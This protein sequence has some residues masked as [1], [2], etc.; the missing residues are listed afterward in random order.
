MPS[1]FLK[2]YFF[3]PIFFC[4][5]DYE[6]APSFRLLFLALFGFLAAGS[7][8]MLLS[9]ALVALAL[10]IYAAPCILVVVGMRLGWFRWLRVDGSEPT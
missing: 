5:L 3:G 6:V 2:F 7:N 1:I 8:I 9:V 4:F 10:F